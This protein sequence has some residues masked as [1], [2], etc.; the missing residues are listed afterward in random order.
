LR[1][2]GR[3]SQELAGQLDQARQTSATAERHDQLVSAAAEQEALRRAMEEIL[4][5]MEQ[6]QSRQDLANHLEMIINWNREIA[7]AIRD[8]LNAETG[9]IWEDD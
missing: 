6:L 4:E 7:R 2:L 8:Q 9:N 3:R 1:Q 5:R